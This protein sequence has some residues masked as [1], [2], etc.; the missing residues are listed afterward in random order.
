MRWGQVRWAFYSKVG[1]SHGSTGR[2]ASKG[3]QRRRGRPKRLR[4]LAGL[5]STSP[6]E[7]DGVRG[8]ELSNISPP[9]MEVY[10]GGWGLV[11]DLL[12]LLA[13]M[14]LCGGGSWH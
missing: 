12:C 2:W 8:R 7:A 13:S 3:A 11:W 14:C 1:R 5:I 10:L 9:E 6:D 4:G